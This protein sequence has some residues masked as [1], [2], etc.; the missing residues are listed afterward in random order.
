MSRPLRSLTILLVLGSVLPDP[1]GSPARGDERDAA[2][3]AFQRRQEATATA[4]VVW[5]ERLTVPGAPVLQSRPDGESD[6]AAEERVSEGHRST[7]I[8]SGDRVRYESMIASYASGDEG[9]IPHVSAYD[10]TRQQYLATGAEVS[11]SIK[12][13]EVFDEWRNIN[14]LGLFLALRPLREEFLGPTPEEWTVEGRPAIVDGRRCVVLAQRRGPLP[15][16]SSPASRTKLIYLDPA[17]DY[18][19]LRYESMLGNTLSGRCDM[20]YE[21][22]EQPTWIPSSWASAFYRGGEPIDRSENEIESVSLGL[23]VSGDTFTI[24]F[25]EGAQVS[26]AGKRDEI[27]PGRLVAPVER[28]TVR[29]G[30]MVPRRQALA[31]ETAEGWRLW[32]LLIAAGAAALGFAFLI[33]RRRT[34]GG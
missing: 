30:K 23:E 17:R 24:D 7:L 3:Q 34:T 28:L 19:P 21:R 10:G 15:Q 22:S 12:E 6:G 25:P 14:L 33:W 9:F 11:G 16:A 2:W 1:L 27:P 5:S 18:V 20:R 31:E 32:P 4:S 13:R 29:D 8:L 26:F